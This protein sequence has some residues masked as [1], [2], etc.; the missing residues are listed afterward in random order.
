MTRLTMA[1]SSLVFFVACGAGVDVGGP[2]AAAGGAAGSSGTANK[3][4]NTAGTGGGDAQPMGG[5]PSS[6]DPIEEAKS[7]ANGAACKIN[8]DCC[9]VTDKCGAQAFVVSLEDRKKVRDLVDS[10]QA[11][12]ARCVLCIPPYV[13]V[14]CEQG[15]CIGTEFASGPEALTQDS[16][17]DMPPGAPPAGPIHRGQILGCGN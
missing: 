5:S 8:A 2:R 7:Y 9:V 13:Q 12:T 16:C 6:T 1:I 10:A 15:K 14:T 4:T 11:E 3:P 17:G